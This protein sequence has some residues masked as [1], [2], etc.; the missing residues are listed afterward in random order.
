MNSF[1]TVSNYNVDMAHPVSTT[2]EGLAFIWVYLVST[3][4]VVVSF[5]GLNGWYTA[6]VNKTFCDVATTKYI[7]YKCVPYTKDAA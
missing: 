3:M 2:F 7:Y 4:V 6:T 1:D 5:L